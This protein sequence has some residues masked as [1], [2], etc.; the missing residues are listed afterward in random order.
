MSNG[1]RS[2]ARSAE[3][4]PV[5]R[6]LA[7]AGYVANGIMHGMIGAIVL[8]V[9]FGGRAESDQT[10]AFRAIAAAPWGFALLW[11]IA[12][13]LIALAAWHT[14][15]AVAARRAT[16]AKRVGIP[17]S[18]I[19][20]AVVFAA[21]GVVAAAVALGARPSAERTAEDASRGILAVPGGA[22]LLGA[23]GLGVGSAG[24]VFVVMGVR[25]SF[26]DK[27][28]FPHNGWGHGLST[29]GVVGFVAKGIALAIV[30]VLLVVAAVRV[31]PD[32]AGGLD[33]AVQALLQLP[34][35]PVLGCAV[36]VGFL[37][38]GVFTV[39]RARFARLSV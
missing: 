4:N 15:A 10:G 7:R 19:G 21:V 25:R 11:A 18:E 12:I 26:R 16:R 34:A 14:V 38:Y 3:R 32:A 33:G 1:V 20:Q 24:I 9:S 37:A 31:Q 22:Y 6:V 17:V 27:V 23:L 13:G 5:L 29:L 2:A 30:G 35:G 8:I 28:V 36:G 39:F